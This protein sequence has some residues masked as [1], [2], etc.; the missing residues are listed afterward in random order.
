[1]KVQLLYLTETKVEELRSTISDRLDWYY[2]QESREAI[3]ISR[4]DLRESRIER[5]SLKGVLV[6]GGSKPHL[7]DPQNALRVFESLKTLTPHQASDERLWT[8]LCHLELPRYVTH[9]WLA[10]RPRSKEAAIRKVRNHFFATTSRGIFRDNG[11]SRLW[12]LGS[13]ANNVNPENPSEFLEIILYRQDIRSALLERPF[14]STNRRILAAI[15][16]ILRSN[17]N[18]EKE[19]FRREIFREWMVALNRR[20][21]IILLDSLSES[22]LSYILRVE[23]DRALHGNS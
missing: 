9:R 20:G 22:R 14:V 4:G 13:I 23:A 8:Y 7:A 3:S 18:N 17:W 6:F 2:N 1:M 19:L 16:R 12:W 21:G 10:L 15:Y 5:E 11:L